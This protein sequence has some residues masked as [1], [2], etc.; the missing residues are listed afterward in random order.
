MPFQQPAITQQQTRS[1]SIIEPNDERI[2]TSPARP[3]TL[4]RCSIRLISNCTP[5]NV[6]CQALYHAINLGFTT[7]PAISIPK[8]LAHNHCTGPNIE[9]KE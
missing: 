8:S 5:C 7:L 6:L 4:L 3:S 9:I 2:A 1:L